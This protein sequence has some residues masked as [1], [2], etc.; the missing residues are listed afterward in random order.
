MVNKKVNRQHIPFIAAFLTVIAAVLIF[1]TFEYAPRV[2]AGVNSGRLILNG[3][4]GVSIYAIDADPNIGMQSFDMVTNYPGNPVNHPSVADNGTVGFGFRGPGD[5]NYRVWAMDADGSNRRQ[6]T[7]TRAL[8]TTDLSPVISPDGTKVAFISNRF[9]VPTFGDG[10]QKNPEVFVVNIDGSNLHQVTPSEQ[11]PQY[12]NNPNTFVSGFSWDSNGTLIVVGARVV[13]GQVALKYGFFRYNSDG[14]GQSTITVLHPAYGTAETFDVRAGKIL[15]GNSNRIFVFDMG[16]TPTSQVDGTTFNEQLLGLGS[17]RL[18]LDGSRIGYMSSTNNGSLITMNLDGSDRVT[19]RTNLGVGAL[20]FWWTTGG[21][22]PA[23]A[24]LELEPRILQI[25]NNGTSATMSPALYDA[26]GNLIFRSARL[27]V[28]CDA[29][30]P[31]NIPFNPFGG[32]QLTPFHKINLT[33]PTTTDQGY[34]TVCGTNVITACSIVALNRDINFAEIRSSVPTANTNGAGGDGVFTIRR[35]SS[36][37]DTS[38]VVDFSLGGTAVRGVDYSLNVA[39]N[40]IVIPAGQNTVDIR[41]TPLLANGNKTV[42]LSITAPLNSSYLTVAGQD[43]AT[44]N[45]IDNGSPVG[46]LS[47]SSISPARGGNGGVVASTIYGSNIANGATVKLTRA[48]ETDILGANV[49]PAVGGKS[50]IAVFDLRGASPGSWSVVVTN[51]DNS[52]QQLTN[53]FQVELNT[54]NRLTAQISGAGEIRA[55]HSRSNYDVVYTNHGNTDVYGVVLFI[56]GVDLNEC[57]TIND[58]NCTFLDTPLQDIPEL[59]GQDPLPAWVRQVPNI[60][61]VDLPNVSGPGTRAVGAIPVLIPRIPANTSRTFRFSM[62]FTVV[63]ATQLQKLNV[64]ILPPL[65]TAVTIPDAPK[66][67]IAMRARTPEDAAADGAACFNSIFQNIVNCALGFVPGAPCIT[68]GL[69][70]LQ[71]LAGSVGNSSYQNLDSTA[72][73]SGAQQ[74]AGMISIMTCLKS[75]TPLGTFLNIIGCFAGVYDSCVT[76][77]GPDS[78]N[79]FNL[80]FVQS[81]DPN[82]KTGV[83]RLTPQNYIPSSNMLY[84]ISFEN[85]P[86]ATAPAQEV[87]I[88]DQLDITK[89]DPSTFEL[90]QLTFGDT[91]I[92]VPTGLTNYA[93]EVD[94]RPANDL[95]V[96]VNA[97]LDQNTGLV[98]WTFISLDPFTRLPPTNALAGFLPP[99]IDGVE[100]TGKV[101]FTISPKSTVITG[102]EIR[103]M[104]TIV[105]DFNE[106]IETNEWL[107]TIDDSKPISSVQA[108]A[109]QQTSTT[110]TVNWSGNDTGSGLNDY[111]LYVSENGG[112]FNPH[113]VGTTSTTTQFTGTYD[114]T[115]AFY[116][117]ARDNAGNVEAAKVVG[118]ATTQTPAAPAT[119]SGTVTYGNAIPA[120]TRYV[121]NVLISGAGTPSV[122]IFTAAPGATAGTYALTGFGAGSYTMTPTKTGGVNSITSFDAA[123]IAQHVTGISNLTGNQLAVADVSNNGTISSFDAGQ[124]ANYVVSASPSGIAGTWKFNPVNRNYATITSSIG[125]ED[126]SALL[127]GEVSGNW[128]NTGARPDN[129]SAGNIS[130]KTAEQ[131]ISHGG[132]VVIPVEVQGVANK[133]VISYEFNL[134]YDPSVLQPDSDPV[135]LSGTVSNGLSF[136]VNAEQPGILRV[137]VYGAYPIEA[138]GVLLNLR[139]SA[140]GKPGSISPITWTHFMFNEGEDE[141][142]VADGRIRIWNEAADQAD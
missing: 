106:P 121:S 67:T 107:N 110:F 97:N 137:A 99:N 34:V 13:P 27:E 8:P 65:V 118:D 45:I 82:E 77:L 46:P 140:V 50:A 5:D 105:F 113:I 69:A 68:A 135:D 22:I 129:R 57:A 14:G 102:D 133:G 6:L 66:P 91:V 142:T 126:F 30:H 43:V 130:V 51:P 136:A 115:Y 24:R 104:A 1:A 62:R 73:F 9:D 88:T 23:A 117:I 74:Y 60:V 103:N 94:L 83:R 17:T 76:C 96:T 63:S 84:G 127:M 44:V 90:G 124:I 123:R 59:P 12:G 33:N 21:P 139:F 125:G 25:P 52:S 41:V 49:Q 79:P 80:F 39:G 11:E 93:T 86:D 29:N 134:R 55:S 119:I 100:G 111:T 72:V 16:G 87:V 48:G 58:V 3:F 138:E 61:P 114:T 141:V 131:V 38:F 54:P 122:S 81:A 4:G 47:L 10:S 109:A 28:T 7:F 18:S 19:V 128:A 98:T 95:I 53:G 2:Q 71:T 85:M 15:Y 26:N 42:N 31:C 108:L 32:F 40:S 35:T 101:L 20:P 75:A 92:N 116:T 89:L 112:A 120:A 36:Q 70:Y 78:C 37:S 56:T 132:E 64:A